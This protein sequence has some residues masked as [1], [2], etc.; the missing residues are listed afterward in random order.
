MDGE[1]KVE[2]VAGSV[3]DDVEGPVRDLDEA[4][5]VVNFGDP[6]RNRTIGCL[7][8]KRRPEAPKGYVGLSSSLL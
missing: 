6:R 5:E 1:Q 3:F 7:A 8:P 4:V 2:E